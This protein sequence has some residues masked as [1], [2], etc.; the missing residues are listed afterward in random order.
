MSQGSMPG[1]LSSV[2]DVIFIRLEDGE[3]IISKLT[4][5]AERRGIKGAFV[6]GIGGLKRAKIGVFVPEKGEYEPEEVEGFSELASLLGNISV[7]PEGKPFPHLHVVVGNKDG[8]VA[9]HLLEAEVQVTAE[10]F[11]FTLSEMLSRELVSKYGFKLIR[12]F[13]E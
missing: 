11:I 13:K 1:L 9:G 4:E 8:I 2:K 5:V 6:T 10:I 3:E 12:D 7:L